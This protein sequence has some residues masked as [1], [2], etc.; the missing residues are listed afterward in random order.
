MATVPVWVWASFLAFMA[1]MMALDL[2]V[3]HRKAH[4]V[5]LREA[6]IWTAVWV[7]L[8]L[9]FDL[10]ILKIQGPTRALEFLTGYVIEESLSVDNLFVFLVIF[11]YFALPEKHY[12][13]VLIWGIIGAVILRGVMIF[14]GVAL[15]NSFS[16]TL[17]LFGALLVYTAVK[18]FFEEDTRVEPEKNPLVRLARLVFPVTHDYVGGR[19]FTA[20]RTGWP[21]MT[22]MFIVLMVVSTADVVFAVDS[23]PAVFAV[24]RDPFI[25]FTSNM[26]AVMG[27]RSVF[28]LLAGVLPK[29]RFLKPGLSFALFFIGAKMLLEKWVHIPV[30]VS[31]G[32]VA[33]ILAVA[34]L[35]SWL[36]PAKPVVKR[37]RGK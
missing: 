24:T 15:V 34:V 37:K 8:A 21:A 35:A 26:F 23:I 19:F 32:A 6:G 36:F 33:G 30:F 29:F 7:S 10:G 20:S 4:A 2:G 28:F 18:L 22:P 1:A 14:G 12:H 11:R 31:L 5:S 16:W 13:R 27:L 17:Y 3:F 9:I 25:I